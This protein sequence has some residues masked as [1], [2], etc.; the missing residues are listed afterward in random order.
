MRFFVNLTCELSRKLRKNPKK[1]KILLLFLRVSNFYYF[2]ARA[3]PTSSLVP[4][5]TLVQALF[6]GA[7]LEVGG[8]RGADFWLFENTRKHANEE[9]TSIEKNTK[10]H[11]I[12]MQNIATKRQRTH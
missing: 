5:K 12:L 10:K 11:A 1:I 2:A 8:A 3:S 9:C 4:L 6:N 7:R